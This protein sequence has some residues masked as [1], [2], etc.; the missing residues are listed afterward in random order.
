MPEVYFSNDKLMH[1]GVL[2]MKWGKRRYQNADGSLKSAG[3]KRYSGDIQVKRRP[4]KD[5]RKKSVQKYQKEH[6]KMNDKANKADELDAKAKELYKAT[7]KNKLS[8]VINNIKN[9]SPEV[10]AYQKA[11]DRAVKALNEIWENEPRMQNLYKQTGSNAI[12]RV[13]N[14]AKYDIDRK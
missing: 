4:S 1:Y 10:K 6:K 13:I 11:S 8:R 2:G 3:K 12:S 5:D 14:N 9:K 7:G